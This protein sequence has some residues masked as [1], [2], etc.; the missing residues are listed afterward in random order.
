MRLNRFR[1]R[2]ATTV[3]SA[4]LIGAA[5]ASSAFIGDEVIF[6]FAPGVA[7]PGVNGD[8][9]H[10]PACPG[11]C[12]N[13]DTLTNAEIM[14]WQ[15]QRDGGGALNWPIVF[16]VG[17]GVTA[18]PNNTRFQESYTLALDNTIILTGGPAL[19]GDYGT[20]GIV[21]PIQ[22]HVYMQATL[23]GRTNSAFDIDPGATGTGNAQ[24][25]DLTYTDAVFTMVFDPDGV[26][27]GVTFPIATFEGTGVG[28][29]GVGGAATLEWI[30]EVTAL[31]DGTIVVPGEEVFEHHI[32]QV[33]RG[34]D[35][36]A[37]DVLGISSNFDCTGRCTTFSVFGEPVSSANADSHI[38]EIPEP[39][40]LGLLGIGLLGAGL[41]VRRRRLA[42]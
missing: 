6:G 21:P 17:L 15:A 27:G 36:F 28:I 25:L 13:L 7:D 5:S 20:T 41:A 30:T 2:L 18:I 37:G 1:R 40:T 38:A 10:D 23:E 24:V 34:A 39:S 19:G 4:V 11:A 32:S 33:I 14:N 29:G 22:S 42:S 9:V 3:V 8:S 16:D 35:I 31:T 26:F 12:T